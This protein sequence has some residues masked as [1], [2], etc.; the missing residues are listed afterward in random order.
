MSTLIPPLSLVMYLNEHGLNEEREEANRY[1][2]EGEIYTVL[3]TEQSSDYTDYFLVEF[4][5]IGFNSVMFEA[6]AWDERYDEFD[7]SD[8]D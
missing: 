8:L 5:Y 6:V 2:T 4:P 7:D 3:H 1:L